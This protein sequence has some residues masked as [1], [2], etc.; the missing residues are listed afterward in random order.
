V[1]P[2]KKGAIAGGVVGAFVGLALAIVVVAILLKAR[3]RKHTP[4]SAEFMYASQATFTR[5]STPT[6][7]MFGREPISQE[8]IAFAY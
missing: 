2:A 1:S 7:P 5:L 8:S 3:A 4:A 6:T